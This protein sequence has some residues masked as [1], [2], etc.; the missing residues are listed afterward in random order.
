MKK[1]SL[2]LLFLVATSNL[3]AQDPTFT[4][5]YSN[6][7]Y[8]NP[9]LAGSSGC[10]RVALNYRNEWPQLTG[11]YVTYAAAYDSYFKNISGGV[12]LIA[13]HDV[14]GQGT[15]QTSMIGASYSNYLKVNR[16]FRLMF[17][18]QAAYYQKYLD[19]SKLTFGD[20][21]DPRR[22]FIYQTGDVPRGNGRR[23][24]FDV[25]A[26][27]V[28]FSKNFYFGAAF[29]HLNR[30]DESM[31]LGQSKL[32]IKVTG[33]IGANIKLGQRGRYSSTTFLSP[34]IIYQNQNGFQQLNVGAYLK[35][36][37]FTIGAWYRNKDAFILTVGINTDNYRIGYSYDLTVS[38]LG[39]GVS[40]GSHE[41]SLGINLKCKKPARDFRRIS[42][43]SF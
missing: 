22:G 8:L 39:N 20:M 38:P 36:E 7:V 37:S 32:P 28:G 10:P 9:A 17:G 34:N 31:I 16:K 43:P 12:G 26:G 1:L 24:F 18:A 30:P 21:I 42:C 3:L 33:H 27:I 41:V 25:S 15:I 40:G 4:Q 2:S 19:W 11:N 5:F 13:L 35:Y 6:P 23:G 14:Q 29:H